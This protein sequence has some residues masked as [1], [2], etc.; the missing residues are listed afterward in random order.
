MNWMLGFFWAWML[1]Q[2]PS[3]DPYYDFSADTHTGPSQYYCDIISYKRTPIAD[4]YFPSLVTNRSGVMIQPAAFELDAD[5]ILAIIC[6][7]VS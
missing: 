3:S 2:P 1:E 5:A 7:T 4:G 6:V